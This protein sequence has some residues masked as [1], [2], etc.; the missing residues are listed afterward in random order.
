[1]NETLQRFAEQ[2]DPERTL[3]PFG[4]SLAIAAAGINGETLESQAAVVR[5]YD[6][7][8]LVP[9][10]TDVAEPHEVTADM[11]QKTLTRKTYST[12]LYDKTGKP[13]GVRTDEDAPQVDD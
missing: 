5:G 7:P 13:S 8:D 2:F 6:S 1:M 4:A 9:F 11:A 10:G 3:P 12:Q